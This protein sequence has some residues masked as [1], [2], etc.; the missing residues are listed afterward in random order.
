MIF[1]PPLQSTSTPGVEMTPMKK[2]MEL[3]R[4]LAGRVHTE[5]R[6][7]WNIFRPRTKLAIAAVPLTTVAISLFAVA[8]VLP[9]QT[10]AN[11]DDENNTFTV[12]VSLTPVFKQNN[13]DPSQAPELFSGGDTFFQEGT[14][15]PAG[16]LPRG[17]ANNDPNEPGGIGKY[18][19]RGVFTE[20]LADFEKAAD[21]LP[22]ARKEAG[23]ATEIYSFHEGRSSIM[24][25]GI[26][27]NP[28]FSARRVVLGGT[29]QFR[30]IV[31][32]VKEEN[33]GENRWGFCNFRVTFHVK[34]L[35]R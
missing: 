26:W 17:K 23:F 35:T 15:Y 29:G 7:R 34:K 11:D 4:S 20:D 33:L 5:A 30:E 3:T 25:D 21:G 22:G 14:I 19:V 12:D 24:T 27:P 31:G 18:L 8:M 28:S 13:V 2:T 16:I 32:E 9:S 6:A 10:W 1:N